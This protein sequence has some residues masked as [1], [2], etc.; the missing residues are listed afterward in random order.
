MRILHFLQVDFL[1]TKAQTRLLWVFVL[2]AVFLSALEGN[3][4][5]GTLYMVFGGVVLSTTPFCIRQQS[6]HG[7]LLMLPASEAERVAG[8]F[9][10]G[11]LMLL[12]CA[13]FGGISM[14]FISIKEGV[15]VLFAAPFYMVLLGMGLFMTGIQY[16]LLYLIGELKSQQ[17]FGIIRM[18][19]GFLLFFAGTAIVGELQKNGVD[20]LENSRW[21]LW[22][23]EHPDISGLLVLLFGILLFLLGFVLSVFVVKRKDFA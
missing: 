3:P 10:Y 14:L 16:M 5:W 1:M 22:I 7:F 18:L 19:P 20:G 8:R 13:C 4:Y 9:L 2:I 21:L 11:A 15:K 23:A 17:V 12:V 6:N